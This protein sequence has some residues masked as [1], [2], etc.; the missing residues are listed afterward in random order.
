MVAEIQWD[1]WT[2]N[3][4]KIQEEPIPL[5]MNKLSHLLYPLTISVCFH[6]LKELTGRIKQH[7]SCI[8]GFILTHLMISYQQH[9]NHWWLHY[10]IWVLWVYIARVITHVAAQRV[11][12]YVWHVK[13]DQGKRNRRLGRS[14]SH[15]P[16]GELC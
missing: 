12:E 11:H 14:N 6:G 4:S 3:D 8:F 9:S 10:I 7:L 16:D 5:R 15:P 2:K 13:W 1:D